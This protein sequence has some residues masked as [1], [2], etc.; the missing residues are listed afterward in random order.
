MAEAFCTPNDCTLMQYSHT[1]TSSPDGPCLETILQ[2]SALRDKLAPDLEHPMCHVKMSIDSRTVKDMFGKFEVLFLILS[3][4]IPSILTLY[5]SH[6]SAK[7]HDQNTNAVV[8]VAWEV[9]D[10]DPICDEYKRI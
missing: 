3:I 1:D 2:N 9:F 8:G 4:Q 5:S 6:L 7:A 10:Q